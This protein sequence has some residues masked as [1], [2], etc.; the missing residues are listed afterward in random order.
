M[1]N[2]EISQY[3]NLIYAVAHTFTGYESKED[4]FQEGYK[5][6][7]MAYRKFNPAL[8]TKFSTYAYSYIWGEMNKYVREDRNMKASRSIRKLK[9][10]IEKATIMLSQKLMRMPTIRE[11]SDYLGVSEDELMEAKANIS[12]IS[13][14]NVIS[15]DGKELTLYDTVASREMDVDTLIA[16]K[17]ELHELTPFEKSIIEA[18][19]LNDMSQQEVANMLGMNQV[20]VSRKEKKIKEKIKMNLAA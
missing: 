14:D 9:L 4:L 20:Q 5:A 10:Q 8:G 2:E 7:M 6:L 3:S 15:D 13:L 12:T 16:F 11:L 17:E 18:R 1:T 19:Y